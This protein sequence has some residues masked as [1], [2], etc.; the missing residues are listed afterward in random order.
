M[1]KISVNPDKN[2]TR[3]YKA[4]GHLPPIKDKWD[5]IFGQE[6]SV[7]RS[8]VYTAVPGYFLKAGN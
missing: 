3:D 6:N 2:Q 7:E 8:P 4:K 1:A 5:H